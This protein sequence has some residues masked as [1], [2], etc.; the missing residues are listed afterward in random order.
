MT[1]PHD[2]VDLWMKFCEANNTTYVGWSHGT[3]TFVDKEGTKKKWYHLT[4]KQLRDL[5]D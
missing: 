1:K 4:E 2:I 5:F 3:H